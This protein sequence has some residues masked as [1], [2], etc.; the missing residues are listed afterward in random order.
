MKKYRL[1]FNILVEIIDLTDLNICIELDK[2]IKANLECVNYNHS[3][4]QTIFLSIIYKNNCKDSLVYRGKIS[5][6]ADW[7]EIN[8]NKVLV[9]IYKHSNSVFCY[10]ENNHMFNIYC[11]R[12]IDLYDLIQDIYAGLR[13]IELQQNY[14]NKGIILH[15]SAVEYNN[16][17]I[18]I[19]GDKGSGKTT[20]CT[21]LI[22]NGA[23]FISSDRVFVWKYNHCFFMN[24]WIGTYRVDEQ[25][26]NIS[27]SKKHQ[28]NLKKYIKNNLVE[29]HCK[30]DNKY[31]FP[32]YDFVK[33][34]DGEFSYLSKID[35]ILYIYRDSMIYCNKRMS[36]ESFKNIIDN[37][38]VNYQMPFIETNS[39]VNINSGEIGKFIINN[40]DNIDSVVKKVEDL[41]K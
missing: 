9:F 1:P 30:F 13:W 39:I 37:A 24:G 21:A 34:I 7:I 18:I 2:Y 14:N 11:E 10:E 23:K 31:R 28:R 22:E 16:K 15:A 12:N 6:D 35:Y 17:G 36:E 41:I 5:E 38:I 29:E 25:S 20:I 26:I 32:P 19:L 33:L 3:N 27:L 8:N 40:N 4:E